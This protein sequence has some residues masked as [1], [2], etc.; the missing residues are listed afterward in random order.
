MTCVKG[1]EKQAV[2][3]LYDLFDSLASQLWP[4]EPTHVADDS[5]GS[6]DN[7]HDGDDIEKMIAR[8]VTS[9]KRPRKEQRFANCQTNTQCVVFISCKPPVDPV[10]LVM[11]HVQTV[12]ETG[13]THTR[14]AQR[15]TPVTASCT[16][17]VLEIR[18]LC[19]RVLRPFF[20]T[21]PDQKYSYKIELRMRN[22]ST[23]TRPE[24][25]Q[26]IASCVPEGHKVDL[27]NAEV[28]IL[29][30]VF[31]SVCGMSIVK[32]YYRFHKFNVMEI[33][34]AKNGT[35]EEGDTGR[36]AEQAHA[37]TTAS[38]LDTTNETQSS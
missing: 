21:E 6:G 38:T 17:N 25:I 35:E 33:A 4:Y 19:G 30:E 12:A 1:K 5:D 26:E 31:K 36:M 37:A 16:A 3:E 10:K 11:T 7:A 27:D 13:V 32:D 22:H 9:I 20:A 29:V 14:Y 15:F 23:L 28:F 34:N 8:E 24:L 2:G 18:S